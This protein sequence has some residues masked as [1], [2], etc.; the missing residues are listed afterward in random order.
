MEN[1]VMARHLDE[2]EK[3]VVVQ[4]RRRCLQECFGCEAQDYFDIYKNDEKE[5]FAM[6]K[7]KSGFC[8]RF[9][10]APNHEFT[11]GVKEEGT[12]AELMEF[13]SPFI[14]CASCFS[15]CCFQTMTMKMGGKDIGKMTDQAYCCVPRFQIVDAEGKG[16]YKVHQPTCCGGCCV[17]CCYDGICNCKTA[18]QVFPHDQEDTDNGAKHAGEIMKMPRSL[19]TELF[20][21]ANMFKITMP[22]GA[23]SEQ[24][25]LLIGTSIF[26]NAAFFERGEN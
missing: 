12:D 22:E 19:A 8:C 20:T 15:C 23:T 17:N 7:E 16:V 26:L 1:E 9:W 18:F 10:C 3:V 14:C 21:D 4:K 13:H 2:S 11:I 5:K 25:G 6:A 24:K